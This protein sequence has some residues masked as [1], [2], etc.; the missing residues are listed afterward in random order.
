M[1]DV[2]RIYAITNLILNIWVQHPDL[3]FFQL[4]DI[5]RHGISP[6]GEDLFYLEDDRLIKFLESFMKF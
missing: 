3:R 1:R 2:R 6:T 5:I 4:I